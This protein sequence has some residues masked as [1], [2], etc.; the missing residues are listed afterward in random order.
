LFIDHISGDSTIIALV[1]VC[2][3][4]QP[5]WHAPDEP[6]GDTL[7]PELLIGAALEEELLISNTESGNGEYQPCSKKVRNGDK[8]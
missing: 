4:I 2:E 8:R 5:Y 1:E 7:A 6:V 3:E